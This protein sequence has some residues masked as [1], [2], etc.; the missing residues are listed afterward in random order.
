MNFDI[1]V[2]VSGKLLDKVELLEMRTTTVRK[3]LNGT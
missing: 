1:A 2:T 3:E